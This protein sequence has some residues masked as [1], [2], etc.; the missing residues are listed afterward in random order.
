MGITTNLTKVNLTP[1]DEY[2][3]SQALKDLFTALSEE[4]NEMIQDINS[5][6]EAMSILNSTHEYLEFY[7]L[8]Y[9]GLVRPIGNARDIT[10]TSYYDTVTDYDS[11]AVY[12]SA[13]PERPT[14]SGVNFLKYLK[15]IYDYRYET[16]TLDYILKFILEWGEKSMSINPNDIKVTLGSCITITLP[17]TS[18]AL[19]VFGVIIANREAMQLPP[20][21]S[22]KFAISR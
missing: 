14:V 13:T 12:D 19:D 3:T 20:F 2:A 17:N 15:F 11:N 9:L 6:I 5:N 7:A 22:L 10:S 1:Y 21:P 18:A 8:Y 16:W 4:L